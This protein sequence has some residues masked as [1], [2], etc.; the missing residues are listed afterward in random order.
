MA[1]TRIEGVV[2]KGGNMTVTNMAVGQ[3]AVVNQI[4]SGESAAL[5]EVQKQMASV[6]EALEKHGHEIVNRDEVVQSVHT[7]KEELSKEKPNHLT[8][9]SLLNGIAESV[10]SVSAVAAAVEGLKLAVASLFG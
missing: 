10:K 7:A 1:Y 2:Q 9:K 5:R 4:Q 8:L 6:L 3:N